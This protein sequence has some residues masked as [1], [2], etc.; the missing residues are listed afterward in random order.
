MWD[1]IVLG[2]GIGGLTAATALAR[3]GQRVLVLE[4][5]QVA[6]GQTQ[7]F[8]RQGWTFATGV[9]YIGGVAPQ[10]GEAGQFGRLL[11]WLSGDALEFHDCGNPYDIVRL[12]GFEFGIEHPEAAYRDRLR[13]RFPGQHAA[14]D[15]WFD[16]VKR[17]RAAAMSLFALR[18]LPA[19]LA[20]G[21]KLW[22]GAEIERMSQRS[23]AQAL[24]DIAD[25]YLAAVLGARWG[26]YG[27]TPDH[28]PLLEHALVTGAYNHGSYFPLGGP[29]RFAQTLVPV[30]RAAGGALELGASVQRIR[31][32]GGRAC[33]VDYVQGGQM[34]QADAQQVIS[35]IGAHNTA[36]CLDAAQ[37]PEWQAELTGFEPGFSYVSLY[38]GLEGD[39]VAA[40]ASAANYWL[41]ASP[42]IGRLWQRPADEDAPGLFV[43]FPSLKDP[44]SGG[45]PTAEVLAPCDA[46]AFAP[47]LGLPP[48]ERPEDYLAFKAWVEERLLA[49][50]AQHFP[51]LAPMVRFHELATPVTQQHYVRAPRGAMYGLEMDAERLGSQALNVRTPVPGLLLAGQDVSGAGVQAAA[52]SGMMAAVAIEPALLRQLSR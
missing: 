41:Y 17:A 1:T 5:H 12:P 50:F 22:R 39:I 3:R 33:G 37:A 42:D 10:V 19:P 13:E 18:A 7:T 14:I 35:A 49:Q 34:H 25:P 23:L 43:S 4:Q 27:A 15:T 16:E 26:D 38:L 30:I 40:G 11:G 24:A 9:H 46:A 32:K 20:W 47:W 28:A 45:P 8:Q 21:M 36:G 52:M 31:V 2:S 29:A 44:S 48:G 6:G 51:A